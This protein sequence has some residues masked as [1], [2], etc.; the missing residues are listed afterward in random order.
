[1]KK[2]VMLTA[3]TVLIVAGIIIFGTV[4]KNSVIQ[5]STVKV[6]SLT[7]ENSIN[8]SGRVERIETTTVY[9]SAAAQIKNVSVKVGDKVEAGQT[10]FSAE[11]LQAKTN[12]S[13][14]PS[15]YE[16]L[17]NQYGSQL[18]QLQSQADDTVMQNIVAP[19][20][21]VITSLSVANLSYVSVGNP[22]AVIA[23]DSGLQIR[24]SV[25]ESQ[26]SGIKV[27]QKADIT[28]VGFKDSSYTG[29]VKSISSDAKQI[30]SATG[31]ETVI[32]VIVSVD[33]PGSD[34]KPGYTAKVKIITAKNAGVLI[35][36]YETVRA[37]KNGNEYVFRLNGNKAVK[38]P[39]V[40]R[41]E[42]DSGFEVIKGLTKNDI[43]IKNPDD[44]SNGARVIPSDSGTVNS[45]G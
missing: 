4:T 9:A 39:I 37:D 45:D 29:T 14:L 28:G 40:T 18:S 20:S 21:G 27:G 26:I 23:D 22:V 30:V 6:N 7:V 8:C 41:K 5:V 11:T 10:L 31:Q 38:T 2:Y 42:F 36:P 24:L 25:N 34:I 16:S 44:L 33:K 35:A 15:G 19:V 17:L 12:I 43:V 1:M 3:F 13:D 32:E